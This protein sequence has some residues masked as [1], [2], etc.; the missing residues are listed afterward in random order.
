MLLGLILVMAALGVPAMV[1]GPLVVLLLIGIGV[2][3]ERRPSA[4]AHHGANLTTRSTE[5]GVDGV[6]LDNFAFAQ[7]PPTRRGWR[8]DVGDVIVRPER[9]H[10][11]G[12]DGD[13]TVYPPF[14][15]SLHDEKWMYWTMVKVEAQTNAGDPTT[16]YLVGMGGPLSKFSARPE[17]VRS[18]GHEL[19][20]EINNAD[21][22]E[23][24]LEGGLNG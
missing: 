12:L 22:S 24:A 11:T 19:V 1:A 2:V 7:A 5:D 15:A 3:I 9:I 8:R 13:L 20:M 23:S 6:L 14:S 10:I 18:R 16:V 4:R 21:T 17:D